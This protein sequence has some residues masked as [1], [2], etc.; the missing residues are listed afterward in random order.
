MRYSGWNNV[1]PMTGFALAA[2]LLASGTGVANTTF[3]DDRLSLNGT[4]K[5]EL[6]HDNQLTGS[7]PVRFGPVSASSQAML[8]APL[9]GETSEG[10]WQ[11]S[12]PWPVSATI[13]ESAPASRQTWKPHPNQ[14]GPTWWRLDLG[15]PATVGSVRIHWVKP[16]T[17]RVVAEVSSDGEQWQAWT[18]GEAKPGETESTIAGAPVQS[19]HLRLTFT[20]A[21]FDGTRNIE[22]FLLRFPG[23]AMMAWSPRVQRVW[24]EE[25]RKYTPADGF[26]L[27]GYADQGWKA[28]QVPGY[29]EVQRFSAPTWYQPDDTVGYYRRTF[30]MPANWRGRHIRL[31]FEGVNNAAQVWVNGREVGY[32]ESGF[33][34]FEYDVTPYLRFGEDNLIAVRVSKWTLTHEYDTDDVWFLGGIW[35][36]VYLYSLPDARIDDYWIRT[37]LDPQYHDAILRARLS[38]RSSQ[39]LPAQRAVVEGELFDEKG[40]AVPL[41][42][43]RAEG[44]LAGRDAVPLELVSPVS[45]PRKWTAE[46]PTLYSLV[47]RL[48]ID[49]R[50]T[51]EFRTTFGFRQVEV[52]GASLLLNGVPLKIRGVVTTRANPNDAGED[53]EQIFDREIRLLKEGNINAIRSHTTPLEEEFLDLCDRHGIYIIPDVPDVWVNEYD[54][55]YLTEGNVLR[56]REIFE[57]H[58]NRTSV[59]AWH[60]GNENGLSSA[61]RGMGRAATWLH[62]TDNTRPVMICS[63]RAD[64]V[65]F[66]TEIND[67]HYSPMSKPQFRGPTPAPVLFGEFHAVPA[68]IARLQDRGFVETWGRSLQREWAEIQKRSWL[69]GGLICCWDDGS[70][71]G[72]LGP[73]QWGVVDSKR[74]AKP[75]HYHVRKVFAPVRL[76]LDQARFEGSRLEATLVLTNLYNFSDLEGFH[77]GWKLMKA[78]Q[79]VRSGAETWRAKPGET[80]RIPL[81]LDSPERAEALQIAVTDAQGYSVQDETFPLPPTSAG[82]SSA[83]DLLTRIGVREEPALKAVAPEGEQRGRLY[84]ARLGSPGE[85]RITDRK[86]RELLTLTGMILQQGRSKGANFPIGTIQYGQPTAAEN[87]WSV[88]FSVPGKLS[89]NMRLEFGPAWL[90]VSYDLTASEAVVIREAGVALR[91]A[92]HFVDM[93]WN[94]Q[95]L[96]N[97]GQPGTADDPLELKIPLGAFAASISRRNVLWARWTG[98]DAAM[99]LVPSGAV[100]NLRGG[101]ARD[102]VVS[103]FLGAGDFLGKFDRE[104][105]ERKLAIGERLDGGFTFFTLAAQQVRAVERLTRPQQDLTWRRRAASAA[106]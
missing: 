106:E 72:N 14:Q 81:A 4:W 59:I 10:R 25:L 93:A 97:A 50:V 63:N 1:R 29:W 6:R 83:H 90:R 36:N 8:I 76:A 31:R 42:G 47:L 61:F 45:N 2:M 21:Q 37:E 94:R 104:T 35:R 39:P 24:Y 40:S 55:R 98:Q 41:Q 91:M 20:P 11:T 46:T 34:A 54:F 38:L 15:Q 33:T 57:Q 3:R 80:A 96:W 32:H 49:G 99:M 105:I 30:S 43:F 69:V 73:N 84:A 95:T 87:G 85:M 70:V 66:G 23:D 102:L 82:P 53:W 79:E 103:D 28:I 5:F 65:E 74:Q 26:H 101:G 56:A 88:P 78:G 9:P 22:V 64:L 13:F 58:K 19:R 100:T 67:D 89:G 60:I 12:V 16:S 17:V 44:V 77:F 75:V 92:P 52:R 86:G 18:K 68:Q 48:R 7:G 51:Q 71:N 62:D 27:P